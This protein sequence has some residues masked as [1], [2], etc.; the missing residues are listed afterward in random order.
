[1]SGA[2]AER[3]TKAANNANYEQKDAGHVCMEQLAIIERYE[4]FVDYIYPVLLGVRRAHYVAR[5]RAI[6]AILEQI[7]LF[8]E[9]GKSGM[10]SRLYAAD[11]GLASLRFYLRFFASPERKLISQHQHQ[12]A[13]IH[14]A[15]SGRMLGAWIR[16]ARIAKR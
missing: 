5:D 7:S 15:E 10:L 8:N 11:A 9:A 3:T 16:R 12:T 14:L 2:E 4:H 13:A 1:M 6:A